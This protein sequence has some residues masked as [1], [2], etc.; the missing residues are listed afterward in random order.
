MAP[1]IVVILISSIAAGLLHLFLLSS[2]SGALDQLTFA[3][4]LEAAMVTVLVALLIQIIRAYIFQIRNRHDAT[5]MLPPEY[6]HLPLDS[7]QELADKQY[8]YANPWSL[9]GL[10]GM[11]AL[12]LILEWKYPGV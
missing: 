2:W 7:R 9:I 3:L 5:R 1:L 12:L 4:V 6:Q 11:V 10:L 8:R